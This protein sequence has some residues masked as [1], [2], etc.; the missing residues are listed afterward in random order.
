[1]IR[2][3]CTLLSKKYCIKFNNKDTVINIDNTIIVISDF[4]SKTNNYLS[5]P[6]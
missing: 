5:S 6:S 1:M 2:S 4:L 3:R